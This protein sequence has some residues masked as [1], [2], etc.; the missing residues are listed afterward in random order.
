MSA[1]DV[2]IDGLTGAFSIFMLIVVPCFLA[3]YVT[4]VLQVEGRF[5]YGIFVF[6]FI[7]TSAIISKSC[8]VLTPRYDGD[9]ES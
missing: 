5:W 8:N 6:V 2:V 7:T 3:D 4:Q 1:L 9:D